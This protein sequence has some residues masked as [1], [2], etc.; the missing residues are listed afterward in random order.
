MARFDVSLLGDAELSRQ[1]ANLTAKLERNILTRAL[2][3]AAVKVRD[4]ARANIGLS[5]VRIPVGT[6]RRQA[7][8]LTRAYN[9]NRSRLR[10]N[11]YV[12]PLKRRKNRIGSVVYTGTRQQLGI[13]D[14]YYYPG[15]VEAGHGEPHRAS[16][17]LVRLTQ[18]A[19]L[20]GRR[21]PPHPYLRP[22]LL[23]ERQSVLNTV[24]AEIRIR[25]PQEARTP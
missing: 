9:R 7:R 16:R 8:R 24:A 14:K 1:L 4:K 11:L 18:Q 2:R 19:E 17:R 25:L 21:T 10:N 5:Q 13:T 15:H 3:S 6:T 23:S 20:G 22:A 12:R